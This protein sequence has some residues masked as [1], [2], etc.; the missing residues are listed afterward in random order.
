MPSDRDWLSSLGPELE[1]QHETIAALLDLCETSSLVSSFSVGCSIGRGAA[2][3]L[4]DVDAAI[5]VHAAR[6]LEGSAEV[7]AVEE[8]VVA[9]LPRVGTV[10]D[11][12]RQESVTGDFL[13][14]RVFAQYDD[15]LQLDLAV[16][17][18]EEVRRGD[19]APDF[20]ALYWSG[21]RPTTTRG[22]SAYEVSAAQVRDWSFLGWRALLD[23]DKYLRRGSLWEAHQR[24][25][26]ARSRIWMLWAAA[27]NAPYP[28]H[29]LSQIL[30]HD[31]DVLPKGIE[32]TVAGLDVAALRG[33]LVASAHALDRCSAAVADARA[34]GLPT[35]M[36]HYVRSIVTSD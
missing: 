20:V 29:G 25:H 8:A 31:P 1:R 14:R 18:E 32:A 16:V 23:A 10:I 6:G 13:I 9:L 27:C 24:L 5:G 15:R 34:G 36:A 28:W 2:D 21:S 3:A 17:A 35:A 12:L 11:V 26:E 4:S 22:P 19:A 33:A 7:H 30:D